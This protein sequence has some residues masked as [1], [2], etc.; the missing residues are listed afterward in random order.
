MDVYLQVKK[1]IPILLLISFLCAWTGKLNAQ[2]VNFPGVSPSFSIGTALNSKLDV[3][4]LAT[5]KIRFGEKTIKDEKY[6]P[7]V[8]EIYSQAL[9]SYKINKHWYI[10]TGYGFQRNNPFLDSWRNESRL[11]QQGNYV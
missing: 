3:N 10:G 9:F 5:S 1:I 8:L 6:S 7:Q 2:D 11:V 4:I